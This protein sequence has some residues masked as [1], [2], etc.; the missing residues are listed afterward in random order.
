MLEYFPL[1]RGAFLFLLAV[2]LVLA[3]GTY[4]FVERPI[5]R[6]RL[7]LVA[8]GGAATMLL[9]AIVG[10]VAILTVGLPE[11]FNPPLPAILLPTPVPH[12]TGAEVEAGNK[13]GP[14]VLLWGDSHAGHLIPR[15]PVAPKGNPTQ[16]LRRRL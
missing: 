4:L 5:R 12:F 15:I 16:N 9:V 14:K 6:L 1:P 11:R 13:T 2:S 10:G 7:R 3:A 8:L